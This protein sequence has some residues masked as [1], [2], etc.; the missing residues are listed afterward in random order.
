MPRPSKLDDTAIHQWLKDHPGWTREGEAL[1][2]TF[3][4]PDFASA[5]A[6]AVRVGMLAE[7]RDHHPDWSNVYNRVEIAL[8]THDAGG[9][10]ER[11]IAFASH[12][13]AVYARF[14]AA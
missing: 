7:K 2:R 12:A 9:I 6:F 4:F 1:V 13:D 5:L 14:R 3:T 11:D 8:T 10:S